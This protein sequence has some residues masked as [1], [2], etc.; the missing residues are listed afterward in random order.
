MTS[1]PPEL[2]LLTVEQVAE[3]LNLSRTEIYAQMRRGRLK[4]VKEG[5]KRLVPP[6]YL[7]DYVDLLKAE[8]NSDEAA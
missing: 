8:A 3:R 4:S 5:R 6:E 7:D 1:D 2:L